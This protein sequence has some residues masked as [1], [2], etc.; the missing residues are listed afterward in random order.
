MRTKG[1]MT[2]MSKHAPV[3]L[4]LDFESYATAL[5]ALETLAGFLPDSK[6]RLQLAADDFKR[7]HATYRLLDSTFPALSTLPA[8]LRPQA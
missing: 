6:T 7:A 3:V 8:L 2:K 1:S 4:C 5:A